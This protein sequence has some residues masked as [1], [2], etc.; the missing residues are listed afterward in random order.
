[1]VLHPRRSPRVRGERLL[2]SDTNPVS[3]PVARRHEAEPRVV[4][5]RQHSELERLAK[6]RVRS[7]SRAAG[8]ERERSSEKRQADFLSGWLSRGCRR[9]RR[10]AGSGRRAR[11]G[12]RRRRWSASWSV[13]AHRWRRWSGTCAVRG[14]WSKTTTVLDT[15]AARPADLA[16]RAIAVIG[17]YKTELIRPVA[18]AGTPITSSSPR[19]PGSIGSTIEGCSSWAHPAR[20]VRGGV[21]PRAGHSGRSGRTHLSESPNNRERFSAQRADGTDD[22]GNDPGLLPERG[23]AGHANIWAR[24]P[25]PVASRLLADWASRTLLGECL[26]LQEPPAG[27]EPATY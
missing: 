20:R 17:L 24:M 3:G 4:Q 10:R 25:K 27:I 23:L 7:A 18:R 22:L 12:S 15:S 1:M 9:R 6:R 13:R 14:R 11:S 21:L 5:T 8:R 2:F 16:K 26:K 19:S